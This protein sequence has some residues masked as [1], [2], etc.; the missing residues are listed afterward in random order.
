M[1]ELLL[2]VGVDYEYESLEISY[3]DGSTYTP[4][5]VTNQYVIEVK[6]HLYEPEKVIKKARAAITELDDRQYVV[7]GTAIP[8]DIHIPWENRGQITELFE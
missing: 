2:K 1:A 6:G 7:V 5:F 3:G 8:A 4:D